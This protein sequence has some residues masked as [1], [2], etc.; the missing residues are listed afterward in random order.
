MRL[1]R[2][3]VPATGPTDPVT[4]VLSPAVFFVA[5][6]EQKAMTLDSMSARLWVYHGIPHL[7]T[8]PSF[9]QWQ[10]QHPGATS[11]RRRGHGV[12]KKEGIPVHIEGNGHG[13]CQFTIYLEPAEP[14]R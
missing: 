3:G 5:G 8:Q 4:A 11:L 1:G 6:H 14:N 12:R 13:L 7:Q 2:N 10:S 9:E